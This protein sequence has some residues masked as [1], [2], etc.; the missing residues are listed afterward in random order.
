MGVCRGAQQLLFAIGTDQPAMQPLLVETLE[1][2][3]SLLL[4]HACVLA[5][6]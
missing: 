1:A 6:R 4:P 5:G 3:D 2:C